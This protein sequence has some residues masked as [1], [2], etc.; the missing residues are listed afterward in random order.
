MKNATSLPTLVLAAFVASLGFANECRG[1]VTTSGPDETIA[2]LIRSVLT[3]G[4]QTNLPAGLAG[5]LGITAGAENLPMRQIA[6]MIDEESHT[7][8]QF[9][10]PLPGDRTD[11]VLGIRNDEGGTLYWMN[12]TGTLLSALK[13][14]RSAPP[15]R[16]PNAEAEPAFIAELQY[17]LAV[18]PAL[19]ESQRPA[20]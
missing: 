5:G 11:V 15:A 18:D 1:Q 12:S 13:A 6:I 14:S 17:W 8:R 9:N 10:V 19:W 16:V 20:R 4:V 7:R 3:H 2:R